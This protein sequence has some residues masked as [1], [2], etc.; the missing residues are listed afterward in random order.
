MEDLLRHSLNSPTFQVMLF[1]SD[2]T[3]FR[4]CCRFVRFVSTPEV[5]ERVSSV[6]AEL[7]QIEE[8]ISIQANEARVRLLSY[9]CLNW[10]SVNQVAI[11]LRPPLASFSIVCLNVL[12]VEHLL[13]LVQ[14]DEQY[15]R[16]PSTPPQGEYEI[17]QCTPRDVMHVTSGDPVV[18]MLCTLD[19]CS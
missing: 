8:A 16:T 11:F 3:A 4:S 9:V 13:V 2:F 14:V 5:L 6:E 12:T 10:V 18:E 19:L 15:L 17:F 7:V 1:S